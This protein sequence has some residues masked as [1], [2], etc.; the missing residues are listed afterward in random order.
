V[1]SYFV[2]ICSYNR[3][4]LFG[5]IVNREMK[6][7]EYGKIVLECWQTIPALFLHTSLDA[8]IIMPN[9]LHGILVLSRDDRVRHASPLPEPPKGL[10]TN[11]ISSIIGSFK[12]AAT[13]KV[14]RYVW[15][16]AFPSGS[17]ITTNMSFET[18]QT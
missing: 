17:A 18:K 13:R 3:E 10:R 15:H 12:S 16:L 2:T 5:G 11:S 1:G 14:T 9:H 6:L 8:F 7:N 4:F